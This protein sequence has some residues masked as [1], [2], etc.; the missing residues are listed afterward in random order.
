M[1]DSSTVKTGKIYYEDAYR[2]SFSAKVLSVEGK[3]VVLDETAFF[4]EEGGQSP[5]RGSLSG[6]TVVDVQIK[7]G[8][9]HHILKEELLTSCWGFGGHG[10]S[11]TWQAH[12]FLGWKAASEA[13]RVR[14]RAGSGL[15]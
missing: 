4:P 1:L 14:P 7:D 3:D 2:V 11:K 6:V 13:C 5:D 12:Q 10:W 8:Y 15:G 9:I